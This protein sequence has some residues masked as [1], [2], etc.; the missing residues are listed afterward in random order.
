MAKGLI[1]ALATMSQRCRCW[2]SYLGHQGLRQS[3][4][5]GCWLRLAWR[6]SWP[7]PCLNIFWLPA[8]AGSNIG[9]TLSGAAKGLGWAVIVPLVPLKP[10]ILILVV[11]KRGTMVRSPECGSIL[12]RAVCS[13]L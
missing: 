7:A 9:E 10:Q 11:G 4:V 1:Q 8:W 5:H 12:I 2:R 6:Q 13:S 3:L